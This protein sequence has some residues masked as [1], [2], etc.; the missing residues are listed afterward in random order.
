MFGRI[1]WFRPMHRPA[2]LS[3]WAVYM[4]GN[5]VNVEETIGWVRVELDEPEG[6][7]TIRLSSCV[8]VL[9]LLLLL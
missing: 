9:V 5:N 2:S 8:R 7:E 4:S 6:I 3:I 1:A